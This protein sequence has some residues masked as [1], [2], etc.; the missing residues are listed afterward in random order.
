[1]VIKMNKQLNNY[2]GH[3]KI[4]YF[5]PNSKE[6]KYAEG[7]LFMG[8]SMFNDYIGLKRENSYLFIQ[9]THIVSVDFTELDEELFVVN[10][11]LVRET[12][13]CSMKNIREGIQREHGNG[14]ERSFQ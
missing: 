1:M 12:K 11:N 8:D 7:I 3:A 13:K 9:M 4:E 2:L 10:L 14:R 5:I 6:S